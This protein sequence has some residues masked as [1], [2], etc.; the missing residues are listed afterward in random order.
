MLSRKFGLNLVVFLAIAALFTGIWALYNR[1][2]TA[3]D[4]PEQISGYSFSPFRQGQSPQTGV[5]PSDQ[6]MREDLELLSKQT[7]SI[8]TY[9][10]DGDLDKIPAIA[11]EFGL[12]VTLGVWISP[13]EERNEREITKAINIA[14]NSRSVVRVVVGNE[15]LFLSLIHI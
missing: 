11:E 2:V 8:R 9:S 1:P 10:V 6:E 12:R 14:N 13:D 5:Y 3:P 7:D 15:A 4:W